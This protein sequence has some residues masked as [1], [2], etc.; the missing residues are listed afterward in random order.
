MLFYLNQFELHLSEAVLKKGFRL[1]CN[2]QVKDIDRQGYF[3]VQ[4]KHCKVQIKNNQLQNFTCDCKSDNYCEHLAAA[5]F[6]VQQQKLHL[7]EDLFLPLKKN[8]KE[9]PFLHQFEALQQIIFRASLVHFSEKKISEKPSKQKSASYFE[10]FVN[11]LRSNLKAFHAKTPLQQNQIDDL[12]LVIQ[13]ASQLIDLNEQKELQFEWTLAVFTFFQYINDY[14][15]SG[16]E[17][18]L[19][20]MQVQFENKL[21]AYYEKGLSAKQKHQW[22]KALL[23]SLQSNKLVKSKAFYFLVPRYL[24]ITSKQEDIKTIETLFKSRTYVKP[25]D[26]DFNKFEISQHMLHLK[27]HGLPKKIK[28]E[29]IDYFDTE[30]FIALVEFY[31]IKKKI[32]KAFE[33]LDLC[34]QVL[35]QKQVTLLRLFTNFAIEKSIY[36]KLHE[37]TLKYLRYS[38]T[39]NIQLKYEELTALVDL[40]PAKKLP[41]EI[42]A[43]IQNISA[44][45]PGLSAEK[46]I[47]LLMLKKDEPALLNYLLKEK[48]QFFL[49][50]QTLLKSP[51]LI[52]N[53]ALQAYAKQLAHALQTANTF[54]RQKQVIES[55]SV[56]FKE[57]SLDQLQFLFDL[58][59]TQTGYES[60]IGKFIS[61]Q[62]DTIVEGKQSTVK[63]N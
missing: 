47:K 3:I 57:I 41:E 14:R 49:L 52:D 1:F 8:T 31:L 19:M 58:I 56:L 10:A 5:L 35:Q 17:K 29:A 34:L 13:Q 12:I 44:Y 42:D 28:I 61:L 63:G 38:L 62:F 59:L 60:Q 33:I 23:W 25:Y 16:D 18:Q 45:K 7:Q 20:I 30:Y 2:G 54:I 53:K 22:L 11:L 24:N 46:M 37:L 15:F 21:H 26:E 9:G 27:I 4:Q 39:Y 55:C 32:N 50:H 40:I 43:L 6:F 51:H 36:L 48:S